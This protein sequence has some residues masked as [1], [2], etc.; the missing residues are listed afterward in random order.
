MTKKVRWMVAGASVLL[1]MLAALALYDPLPLGP[2]HH[3]PSVDPTLPVY[4]SAADSS[5]TLWLLAIGVSQYE[6]PD[7]N[8]RFA[9]ADAR[10]IA[11]AIDEVGGGRL[12][13]DVRIKVLT[14]QEVSRE[15]IL[16]SME[17]FL[18]AAGPNDVAALFVA[19]H[20][21]RDLASGTYYFLPYPATGENLVTEGL[22][23]TD[24]DAML[25][26]LRRNVRA[27][28]VMLDTCHAGAFGLPS[29]RIV[30]ADE[31]A[32]QMSVGDGF[33]LLAATKPGEE[34]KEKRDLGHGAFTF[35]LLEA[36]RGA[37]D[38]DH[39]GVISA[40]ELFAYVAR[41]VPTLTD[42]RQHPYHRM[43]GTD[44]L[45]LPVGEAIAAPITQVQPTISGLPTK[46]ASQPSLNVI[47]VM[48]FRDLRRDDQYAWISQALRVAFNTELSKVKALRVYS[49]ELIDQTARARGADQLVT[50]RQLGIGRLFTG[51]FHVTD[52]TLRIDASIVDV[53]SGV[54][55][56][57]DSVE[58]QLDDFFDL[59]K[60]LVLSMLRRLRVQ[61]SPE[62]GAS[63]QTRTNTDVDAYRLLLESEGVVGANP[64]SSPT[65]SSRPSQDDPRS[66]LESTPLS[67]LWDFFSG[68]ALAAE[69]PTTASPTTV[70]EQVRNML[71]EYQKALEEKAIDR[72]AALYASFSARQRDALRGY[73]DAATNLAV[74][75][76]DVTVTPHGIDIMVAFTRRDSFID[77]ESEKPV[78][79]EVRLT[80]TLVRINGAWKIASGQ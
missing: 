47:G 5:S 27:V 31:I 19:G 45:F 59:Q 55:E 46:T 71:E 40:S 2:I 49:P 18:G 6:D 3:T 35:A 53:A 43:E 58:G 52:H 74:E 10:A 22:R 25:R 56:A 60:Q 69:T 17:G 79:L 78:H 26:V 14:N 8:L 33:F 67:S 77:R 38:V 9:D 57:S 80:K 36:M 64:E 12:Y 30:P 42:G 63:I 32:A 72:V 70:E 51:S 61:V 1:G 44:L 21:V 76:D 4:S 13:R 66:K 28:V 48:A 29:T 75:I 62:E 34:S 50:A 54:N 37:A 23:M 39:D 24:F 7:L 11:D 73:L 65:Q 15:S 16:D 20:G 41:R 68:I